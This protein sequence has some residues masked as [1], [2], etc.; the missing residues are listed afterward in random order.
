MI[1][2]STVF[3]SNHS[4]DNNINNGSVRNIQWMVDEINEFTLML[5]DLKTQSL[6]YWLVVKIYPE[7]KGK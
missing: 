6:D 3:L 7:N 2:K 1:T 4:L 5:I